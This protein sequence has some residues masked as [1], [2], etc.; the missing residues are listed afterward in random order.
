MNTFRIN[1]PERPYSIE[2]T[3]I[4]QGINQISPYW[5]SDVA[6]AR[7]YAMRV[8]WLTMLDTDEM[9][10]TMHLSEHIVVVYTHDGLLT[11]R[12]VRKYS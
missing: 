7:K 5:K 4:L 10:T 12:E 1:I 9:E 8:N 3:I 6:E 11:K 2:D